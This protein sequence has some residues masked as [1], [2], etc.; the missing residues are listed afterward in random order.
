VLLVDA[1]TLRRGAGFVLNVAHL[2]L[3]EG[4]R[5]TI[6]GPSGSGK[7]TLLRLIAGL[8]RPDSGT[9]RIAGKEVTG[10]RPVAPHA[11][12][13]SL[14]SQDYGLWAHLDALEHLAFA[15]SAGRSL[16]P[17]KHAVA[18]LDLVRLG[19]KGKRLPMTLSGGEQ[20]R[21]ALAR[22][23]AKS[24]R[25]LL[26]D[27]PGSNLDPVLARDLFAL[28]DELHITR[29]LTRIQ[30]THAIAQLGRANER[31]LVMDRG[32]IVQ[33]GTWE[34]LAAA[35]ANEWVGELTRMLA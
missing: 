12:P 11:R 20:Q 30:V 5:V 6:L 14:L 4:E 9:I 3:G 2:A 22:A 15:A 8:E 1:L 10:A 31:Y 13:V 19:D 35:P 25:L 17:D 33:D 24:P 27:E 29:G 32:S 21:L 34:S 16:H 28:L 26:L 7:S 18:L 23:L